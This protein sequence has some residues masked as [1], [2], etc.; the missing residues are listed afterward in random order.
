MTVPE[1][2]T[3]TRNLTHAF[4]AIYAAFLF[5]TALQGALQSDLA[6]MMTLVFPSVNAVITGV[7]IMTLRA[8]E[9]ARLMRDRA[10][11]TLYI[12]ALFYFWAFFAVVDFARIGRS[13][14][15]D[16][17]FTATFALLIAA[18][19]LRLAD[20]WTL[21]RRVAGKVG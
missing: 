3:C 8:D 7:L 18:L 1:R 10:G 17:F 20:R 12:L 6:P 16:P 19:V 11:R 9:N 21:R 13:R 4:A 5:T 14:L 2:V 15:T